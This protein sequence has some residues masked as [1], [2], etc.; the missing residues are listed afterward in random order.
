MNDEMREA[1]TVIWAFA[2]AVINRDELDLIDAA[3]G[4]DPRRSTEYIEEKATRLRRAPLAWFMSLDSRSQAR[5]LA[6]IQ[7]VYGEQARRHVTA[8]GEASPCW[9]PCPCC[10]AWICRIHGQHA[11]DCPCPSIEEWES[12]GL[13]PYLDPPPGGPEPRSWPLAP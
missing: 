4:V 13:N 5:L 9:T 12:T 6:W 3:Y 2:W 8:S 10:D 1:R 11:H 7:E